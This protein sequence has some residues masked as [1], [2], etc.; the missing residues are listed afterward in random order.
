[1]YICAGRAAVYQNIITVIRRSLRIQMTA[2]R[3]SIRLPCAR[4]VFWPFLA[5]PG[6]VFTAFLNDTFSATPK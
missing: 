5:P 3:I 4:D 1:M 2:V 6:A